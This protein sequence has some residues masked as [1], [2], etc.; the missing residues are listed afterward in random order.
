MYQYQSPHRRQRGV[1]AE[2]EEM[3]RTCGIESQEFF[4]LWLPFDGKR[5]RKNQRK[6]GRIAAAE[7]DVEFAF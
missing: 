2:T 3:I 6:E 1:E 5:A 7:D 4:E